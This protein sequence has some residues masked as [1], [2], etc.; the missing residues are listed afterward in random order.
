MLAEVKLLESLEKSGAL[1][2][3]ELKGPGLR[4]G[5]DLGICKDAI[6]D[7]FYPFD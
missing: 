5:V 6:G 7:S 2:L 3:D 1:T 4:F